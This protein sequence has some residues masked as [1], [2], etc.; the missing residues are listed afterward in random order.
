[1]RGALSL[2]HSKQAVLSSAEIALGLKN[3]RTPRPAWT[4]SLRS[5][6]DAEIGPGPAS[7]AWVSTW[8]ELAD[9]ETIQFSTR[10]A[11]NP[12][13]LPGN[14]QMPGRPK[15]LT[16][17]TSR[18]LPRYAMLLGAIG[19]STVNARLTILV[20]GVAVAVCVAILGVYLR[21]Y[22]RRRV[23]GMW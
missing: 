3:K 14:S 20:V 22:L 12:W 11:V 7:T 8:W 6:S 18:N 13:R 5:F 2:F 16:T 15:K 9:G 19:F 17:T 4:C 23:D 21:R 10:Y 1:M